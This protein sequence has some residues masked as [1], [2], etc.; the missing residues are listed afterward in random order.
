MFRRNK[1]A[2]VEEAPPFSASFYVVNVIFK[3]FKV[4]LCKN[5]DQ[6]I[7]LFQRSNIRWITGKGFENVAWGLVFKHLSRDP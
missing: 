7:V 1:M 3:R 6:P 5:S 4:N 2:D